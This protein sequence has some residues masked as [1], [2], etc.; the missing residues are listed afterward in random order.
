VCSS[1]LQSGA[2][3]EARRGDSRLG[4]LGRNGAAD[5]GR[6]RETREGS[7]RGEGVSRVRRESPA[8]ADD[9]RGVQPPPG[10]RREPGGYRQ[11]DEARDQHADGAVRAGGLHRPRHRP[12][13]DGDPVPGDRG[14]EVPSLDPP[15]EVRPSGAA[16][17]EVGPRRV[18]LHRNLT[19]YPCFSAT[20]D[21]APRI[22]VEGG[23]RGPWAPAEA[24]A[25]ATAASPAWA[26]SGDGPR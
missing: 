16:R 20:F 26:A 24:S 19:V 15:P 2:G 8:R 9:E 5:P 17:E 6:L 10:G 25:G 22:T 3:H 12:R 11:G 13:R 14:P 23:P 18:R 4:D 1:D 7:R 21:L